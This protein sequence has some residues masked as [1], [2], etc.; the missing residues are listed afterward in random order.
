MRCRAALVILGMSMFLAAQEKYSGPHPPKPDVAY[1]LH[2]DTLVPTEVAEANDE[3]RK[4]DILYVVGGANSPAK[5]PLAS[6]ILLF[7]AE[8]IQ[9]ERLQLYRLEST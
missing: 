9:P 5:T 2:G 7:Q 1:L 3:H 8:K 4:D 6:P